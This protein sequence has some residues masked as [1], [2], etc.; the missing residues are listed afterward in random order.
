MGEHLPKLVFGID[1]V[2]GT[3]AALAFCFVDG[4]SFFGIYTV[5]RAWVWAWV[6]GSWD[7]FAVTVGLA[8]A[9]Q[10]LSFCEGQGKPML[11]LAR[12]GCVYTGRGR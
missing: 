2:S 12:Y 4:F 8:R 1:A 6:F 5:F 3:A 11:L 10:H 7:E 9:C